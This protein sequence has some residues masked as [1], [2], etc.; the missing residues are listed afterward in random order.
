VEGTR[1]WVQKTPVIKQ[2]TALLRKLKE[3][4]RRGDSRPVGQVVAVINPIPRG[5]VNYFRI[6]NAARCFA[7]VRA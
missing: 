6:G 2:R 4:F 3:V 5:W 1:W 7:F